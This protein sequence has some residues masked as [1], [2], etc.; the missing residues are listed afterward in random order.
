M[1]IYFI[2]HGETEHNVAQLLA[3]IT[4]SRLTQHG[5]LQ[6]QR[7]GAHL[8]AKDLRFTHIFASDLQR[9]F[10]TA[11]A[12]ADVQFRKYDGTKLE[13]VR[14]AHLREQDFGSNEMVP[15]NSKRGQDSFFDR[16][17][18]TSQPGYVPKES[19]DAMKKRAKAFMDDFIVPLLATNEEETVAVVSHG[20]FLGVLW[21]NFLA[22][23]GPKSVSLSPNVVGNNYGA[24]F[25]PEHHI[26]IWA[27]T[28]YLEVEIQRTS[29]LSEA[30]NAHKPEPSNVKSRPHGLSDWEMV[31]KTINGQEHIRGF[32]KI[33]GGVADVA[34][35]PKQ[36]DI[37]GFFKKPAAEHENAVET[38]EVLE[39]ALDTEIEAQQGQEVSPMGGVLR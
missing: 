28:A 5:I 12:I 32:K 29:T 36:K 21:R 8:T 19:V 20:L 30:V 17:P 24:D 14:L 22:R 39:R 9:A 35:D 38:G 18:D 10:M 34:H 6:T 16:T 2:R 1:K 26:A 27:N 3:G 13:V 15:W 37:A 11:Q 23:F 7:L 4:D 31:I 25:S 33:R